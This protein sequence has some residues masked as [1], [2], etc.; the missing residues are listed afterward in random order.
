[1][2]GIGPMEL[3]VILLIALVVFGPKKIPEIANA[4]GKSINEFKKGAKEIESSVRKELET[5]DEE[6]LEAAR[7]A[8][9]S[10]SGP[11]DRVKH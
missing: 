3:F 9:H 8:H 1:M 2:F 5:S 7:P 6:R 10:E 11:T 4:L